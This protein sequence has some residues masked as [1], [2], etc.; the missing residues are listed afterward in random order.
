MVV[1][2]LPGPGLSEELALHIAVRLPSA[3]QERFPGISWSVVVRTEQ[4]AGPG[5]DVDLV[6]LARHR[7][8]E[9]GWNLVI[10]LTARPLKVGRRPVTMEASASLGVGVISVPALGAIGLEHRLLD[11]VLLTIEAILHGRGGGDRDQAHRNERRWIED[12]G[13]LSSS[14]GRP[15]ER[16]QGTISFATTTA[17]GNL[18]LLVGSIRG[19]RPWAMII[20]LSSSLVAALGTSAFGLTSPVIWR[21]ANAMPL[22]RMIVL[23]IASLL[24]IGFTLMTAHGLWEFAPTPNARTRVVLINLATVSTVAIGV[25][26]SYAALFVFNSFFGRT[27]IPKEV[28][29]VELRHDAGTLSYLRIAW[30][31]SSL[32]TLGGA[33]GA[34]IE[35]NAAV[36]AA[37]YCIRPVK[38]APEKPGWDVVATA[39]RR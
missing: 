22:Q 25:L 6:Q 8:L 35:T 24:A 18:R 5:A 10:C 37:A 38:R 19:N 14:V 12:L 27:L 21:I 17:R 33:L 26:T 30:L 7:M 36:R 9:E 29:Q 1:G 13:K 11:A 32:A 15:Y 4:F 20:G 3:L 16:E 31:V 23:A 2:L 39:M 28:L 34:V